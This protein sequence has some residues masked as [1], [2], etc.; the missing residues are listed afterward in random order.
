MSML[1]YLV[2]FLNYLFKTY[3]SIRSSSISNLRV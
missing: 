3:W 2:S 1:G